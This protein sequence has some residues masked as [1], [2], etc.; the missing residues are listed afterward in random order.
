MGW[1]SFSAL[2]VPAEKLSQLR[3]SD[4]PARGDS[5]FRAETSL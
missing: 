3:A 5:E 2:S 4:D 1:L